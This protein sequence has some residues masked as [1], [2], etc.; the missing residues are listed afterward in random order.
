MNQ[1]DLNKIWSRIEGARREIWRA[2]LP[3]GRNI[4][5][6]YQVIWYDAEAMFQE[7]QR[8]KDAYEGTGS[9]DQA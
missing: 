2:T 7:I 1:I 6:V 3:D 5:N 8:L 9:Q 4:P